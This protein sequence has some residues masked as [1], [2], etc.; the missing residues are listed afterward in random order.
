MSQVE[1]N[2]YWAIPSL[3]AHAIASGIYFSFADIMEAMYISYD[4]HRGKQF[5]FG[6]ITSSLVGGMGV[7]ITAY[8]LSV[9]TYFYAAIFATTSIVICAIPVFFL[10]PQKDTIH[11]KHTKRV[12]AIMRSKQFRPFIPAFFGEQLY[13]TARTI[14]IPLFIFLIVNE[15]FDIFGYLVVAASIAEIIITLVFGHHIDRSGNKTAIR[16]SVWVTAATSLFYITAVSGPITAFAAETAQRICN[17]SF[18]SSFRTG[19]HKR[20]RKRFELIS[21]GAAWQA[22]S[23]YSGTLTLVILASLTYFLD[24]HIFT[25]VFI[26]RPIGVYLCSKFLHKMPYKR[27]RGD[28]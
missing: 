17:N 2:H 21:F 1:Y 7:A 5:V 8:I 14:F 24:T 15:K 20:A 28:K 9:S 12:F 13:I 22:T 10:K 27:A 4:R 3:I 23:C 16:K 26:L 19:L 11:K 18:M 6:A 25:I